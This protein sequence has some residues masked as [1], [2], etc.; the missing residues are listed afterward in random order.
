MTEQILS[1][2]FETEERLKEADTDYLRK[3]G[4]KRL[5]HREVYTIEETEKGIH[6]CGGTVTKYYFEALDKIPEELPST[7]ACVLFPK[8]FLPQLKAILEKIQKTKPKWVS[9]KREE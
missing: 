9:S 4:V 7:R 2:K 1:R 3:H 8:E 6:I 5:G